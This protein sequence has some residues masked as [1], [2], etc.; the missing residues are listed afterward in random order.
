MSERR[1][2]LDELLDE[3]GEA[4]QMEERITRILAAVPRRDLTAADSI[5]AA[6]AGKASRNQYTYRRS[7]RNLQD[8]ARRVAEDRRARIHALQNVPDGACV[9]HVSRV[10]A[11]PVANVLATMILE[12]DTHEIGDDPA[13]MAI[14]KMVK[15][16]NA[17]E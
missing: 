1:N 5:D 12:G 15:T 14:E 4:V 13:V 16:L 17:H 3:Y 9:V 8:E 2:T 6:L 10:L 11:H 7:L